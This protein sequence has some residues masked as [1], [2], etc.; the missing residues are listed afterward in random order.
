MNITLGGDN[1]GDIQVEGG[2]YD[3][4]E[5]ILDYREGAKAFLKDH[6]VAK[7][8]VVIDTHCLENGAFVYAGNSNGNDP[9]MY[10]GCSL[11]EVCLPKASSQFMPLTS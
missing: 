2:P 11:L 9:K 10:E 8:V 4:L 5:S 3:S 6:P 7:I 1:C